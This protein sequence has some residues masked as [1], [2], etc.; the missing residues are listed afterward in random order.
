MNS[1]VRL[2]IEYLL[3]MAFTL[4]IVFLFGKVIAFCNGRFYRTLGSKGQAA[5]YITGFIGTPIHESAHAL[6]CLIF[7]H[8]IVEIKFF[9]LNSSDGT[10]GYVQHSYN[11][12]NIWQRLGN[13]FIGIAPILVGAGLLCL[14]L[15]LLLPEMFAK[16]VGI[17]TSLDFGGAPL[18]SV[19]S[20]G[21]S[22]VIMFDYIDHWQWWL[23]LILGSFIALHMTLSDADTKG[24]LS[25]VIFFLLIFLVIDVILLLVNVAVLSKFTGVIMVFG[26]FMVF[27]LCIFLVIA[28]ALICIAKLIAKFLR[29]R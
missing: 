13:L 27:F 14:L 12:K 19:K 2:L 18:D 5:C 8:K 23:F 26:N 24:A 11:P 9:Q 29:L 28:I 20:I 16:V 1:F 10:L 21:K 6:M 25:G 4:G 17:L 15:Y 3:Q 22:F 7:G